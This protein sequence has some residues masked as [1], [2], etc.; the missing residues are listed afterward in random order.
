MAEMS[1][2]F[3][4]F[5]TFNLLWTRSCILNKAIHRREYHVI[6]MMSYSQAR[7]MCGIVTDEKLNVNDNK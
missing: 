3:D 1:V 2:F 5:C 4:S 6:F 7:F